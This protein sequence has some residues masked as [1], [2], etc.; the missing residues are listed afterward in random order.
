MSDQDEAQDGADSDLPAPYR[1]QTGRFLPGNPGGPGRVKET[2]EAEY[3]RATARGCTVEDWE[4]IVR[5]A[6]TDCD[7]GNVRERNAARAFLVRVLFGQAPGALIQIANLAGE[8][9]KVPAHTDPDA[10]RLAIFKAYGV[11]LDTLT[12]GVR[13]YL[14]DN[15]R[16]GAGKAGP[17]EGPDV[18]T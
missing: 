16:T 7:A 17:T 6:V 9:G 4:R 13:V 8:P 10:V 1:D 15:Q 5:Q 12:S 3:H 18:L 2:T 11:D 14:P